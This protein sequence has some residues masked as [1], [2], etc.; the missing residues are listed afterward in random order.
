[1]IVSRQFTGLCALSLC[2]ATGCQKAESGPID[3]RVGITAEELKMHIQVLSS[4]EFE[5]R[6]PASEGEK[7]TIAYLKKQFED[8][9]L[10][11]GNGDSYFQ[12]VPL[13]EISA[14][15]DMSLTVK[16]RGNTESFKY[17]SDFVAW[18]TRMVKNVSLE[19]SD[20]VFVGYGIVAPEYDWNDYA[21]LNVSGKTVVMLVNDPGYATQ[22]QSLFN[23]NAMTYY[24]RWTYKFEEAARQGAEG[25]IIIH[26]VGPAGY[27]WGVVESS[28]T[29]PQFGLVS[30]NGNLQSCALEVWVTYETAGKIFSAA[31]KNLDDLTKSA[32]KKSF[33]PVN[34]RLKASITVNNQMKLSSS[35]NVMGLLRGSKSPDEIIIYT[36][37]WD[38]LGIDDNLE[39]DKIYNGALDN[40]TGTAGLLEIAEAFSQLPEKPERSILFLAVTAEE[41][42]LLGSS[43]YAKHPVFPIEQT[44]ANINMDGLNIV[45]KMRDVTV[46]GYGNSELDL[47]VDEVARQQGRTVIPDPS[48]EKGYYYRSDH[49]SFAKVGIPSLYI[50]MGM[51]H[52]DHGVAYTKAAQDDYTENRYHKPSDEFDPNWDLSGAIDDLLLM[53]DIGYRLSNE[54]TFPNWN[55]GNEF[56]ALRDAMMNV[57]KE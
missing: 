4:D 33:K 52:V 28:W 37:H 10:E 57:E 41:Q 16:G 11:P 17:G 47:Y 13:L 18:T 15:S 40:A 25:A 55:E 23:G 14:L 56:R 29:G 7:K 31:G 21:G 49:F 46:I 19:A 26:E 54:K 38:H 9:G 6:G 3:V 1:M 5:G 51:D 39:G 44:V 53:Y 24:G 30:E 48:P 35:Y 36:A 45:G 22:D 8:M 32:E 2:I 42:G 27:G 43:Y 34:L 12:N 50:E 20:L